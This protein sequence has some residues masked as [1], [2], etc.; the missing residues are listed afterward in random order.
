MDILLS[1]YKGDL[2]FIGKDELEEIERCFFTF[3]MQ[4]EETSK[5]YYSPKK[6]HYEYLNT[7]AYTN[8]F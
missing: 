3:F 8:E 7:I 1:Y 4:K 2:V 5:M 6:Y